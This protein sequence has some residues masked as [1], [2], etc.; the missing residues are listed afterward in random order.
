MSTTSLSNVQ[1][2]WGN[3]DPAIKVIVMVDA[4]FIITAIAAY[5]LIA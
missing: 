5:L 2:W 3:V 1:E 4:V